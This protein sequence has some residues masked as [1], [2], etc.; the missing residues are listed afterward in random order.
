M[1]T[2]KRLGPWIACL[3]LLLN[4]LAMPMSSAMQTPDL[5]LML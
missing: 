4:M 3:A 5:Q 1:L 2:L